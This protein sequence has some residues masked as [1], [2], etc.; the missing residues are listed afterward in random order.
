M[1]LKIR[2]KLSLIIL[3]FSLVPVIVIIGLLMAPREV[4]EEDVGHTVQESAYTIS[5][6]FDR[7]LFE[8]Y[9][10]VQAFSK[11]AIFHNT[12]N[13][14]SFDS[15][16]AAS[17]TMN[18]YINIYGVY[19]V[20]M[21]L[22]VNGNIIAVN[23]NDKAG[24][25]INYNSLISQNFASEKWFLDAKEG[26]F[27]EGKNGFT[28]TAVNG[29]TFS[30]VIKSAFATDESVI[31]YSSPLIDAAGNKIGVMATFFDMS[32]I[33]EI[34]EQEAAHIAKNINVK[35]L[36]VT[37]IDSKGLIVADFDNQKLAGGMYT[38]DYNVVGKFNLIEAGDN[39]AKAVFEGEG[40]GFIKQYDKRN[41]IKK[42]N[43]FKRTDGV[44]DY[45]GLGW[46]I[47]VHTPQK[48]AYAFVKKIEINLLISILVV[49]AII[50]L[51]AQIMA[52]RFAKP[53]SEIGSVINKISGGDKSVKVPHTIKTD[54]VGDIAR[55]L[56]I[57]KENLIKMDKMKAEQEQQKIKA[58]Q[59]RKRAMLDLA[60]SFEKRVQGVIN[61]VAAASTELSQTASSML[62]VVDSTNDKATN[63][64]SA[65]S[66]TAANIN[67]IS[68]AVEELS[69]SVKEINQQ[70][71]KSNEVVLDSVSKTEVGD[72]SAQMLSETAKNITEVVSLIDSIAEQINLL[73]LNAT[74]ESA[75]AGE[76]GKGFAV[77]ANE[78][79][80]LATQTT[81]ATSEIDDKIK[82]VRG[83]STE[84]LTALSQIKTSIKNV[85][86]YSS[87]IAAA[88]EEQS[89]TTREI[90]SNMS[91]AATATQI[92]DQSLAEVT[93]ASQ[94]AKTSAE[95]VMQASHDLSRQSEMLN[96]EV[97]KFLS[98]VRN[99]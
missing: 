36:A 78:I 86:E 37:L 70:V 79:K 1:K 46:G 88:V 11:N 73:A 9:G 62:S 64:A 24:K 58:E 96:A 97:G 8:R 20:I 75:R 28:G 50:M 48:E 53:I 77:V 93:K 2:G 18:D 49:S 55:A 25:P 66:E 60:D 33:Y 72:K 65:S 38:P 90:S 87:A 63:A 44:Y 3:S 10:D 40:T 13:W 98:E 12:E 26:K 42:V 92:V 51:V 14:G 83:V 95:Q 68:A 67:T 34:I 81:K 16:S 4:L 45:P 99:G 30:N 82:Q 43:G 80:N 54:E 69:S 29:P 15:G 57:F 22:D 84:V 91:T 56:E 17:K 23:T 32:A 39:V 41:N 74:I 6:V 5:D 21:A 19:K 76:A 7:F 85:S 89:A 47:I 52:I 94:D 71:S 27:L 61:S 35:S 59:D 31:I